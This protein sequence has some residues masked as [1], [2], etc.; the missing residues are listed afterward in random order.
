MFF[1]ARVVLNVTTLEDQNDASAANGLSLRDAV[2]IAQSNPGREYVIN[3]A[4]GTYT[5]TIQ[6][7]EDF[8]FQEQT[9]PNLGLFDTF[10]TRTGDIDITTRITM[11]GS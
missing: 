4:P 10:V 2:L 6:G 3:L 8:R 5:L 1:S 7:N 9:Q 11:R